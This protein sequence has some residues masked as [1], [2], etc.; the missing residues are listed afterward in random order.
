LLAVV[1][2]LKEP[3]RAVGELARF[4]DA[5]PERSLSLLDLLFQPPVGAIR[6]FH[7][8]LWE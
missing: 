5:L 2:P 7:P 3:L 8:T 1:L 6:H 4:L